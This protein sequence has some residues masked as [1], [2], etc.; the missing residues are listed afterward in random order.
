MTSSC[1][2]SQYVSDPASMRAPA[3]LRGSIGPP[4][5]DIAMALRGRRGSSTTSHG[6]VRSGLSWRGA[7]KA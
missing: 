1:D 6:S 2:P 7:I 4:A 3:L 5:I